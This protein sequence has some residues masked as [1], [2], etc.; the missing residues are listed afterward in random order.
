MGQKTQHEDKEKRMRQSRDTSRLSHSLLLCFR[1]VSFV[2]CVRVSRLSH[3]LLFVFVVCLLFH[4]P[5]S[6]ENKQKRMGQSRDTSKWNKRH[7]TKTNKREWDNLETRTNGTKDTARKQNKR[8]FR[9]VSS[10]PL[11]RVSRLS[12]SL[13]FVF[14]LCLLSHLPVSLDCLILICL[15]SCCVF[16]SICPCTARKQTKENETI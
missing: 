12:H 9:A 13:L 2:P 11:A 3:S 7:S 8:E 16:C 14:V 4:L 1:A 10:V 5:V 15:F 6:L